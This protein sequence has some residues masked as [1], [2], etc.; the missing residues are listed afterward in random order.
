MTFK[1]FINRSLSIDFPFL[2]FLYFLA[3]AN[4]VEKVINNGS[5]KSEIISKKKAF[6]SMKH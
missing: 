2:L 6:E 5:Q 4:T 1:M 3:W